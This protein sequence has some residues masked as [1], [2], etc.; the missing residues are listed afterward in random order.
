MN[1]VAQLFGVM[2][3]LIIPVCLVLCVIGFFKTK[4]TTN[5]ELTKLKKEM[6]LNS[7]KDM[8][9]EIA[10][11]KERIVVLEAIVT[12]RSFEVERKIS[13]L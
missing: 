10:D 2:M 4:R 12:D 11:L 3:A 13:S 5:E 9:K 7:N 8:E 6:K 1:A